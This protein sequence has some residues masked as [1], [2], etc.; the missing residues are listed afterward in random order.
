MRARTLL[1]AVC[2]TSL[3]FAVAHYQFDVSFAGIRFGLSTGESFQWFS[4]LFRF[5]AGAYFS[6]LFLFR[7]FGITAGTHALYYVY[8]LML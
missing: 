1:P 3:L 8:T 5:L 2:A 4:F 6:L 7:G